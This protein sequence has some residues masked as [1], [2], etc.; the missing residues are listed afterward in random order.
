MYSELY[1]EYILCVT[2]C[3]GGGV[4]FHNLFTIYQRNIFNE[5]LSIDVVIVYMFWLSL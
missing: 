5:A 1:N 3:V 4:E 2:L